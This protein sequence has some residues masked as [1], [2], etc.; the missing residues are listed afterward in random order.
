[1]DNFFCLKS[2]QQSG[3]RLYFLMVHGSNYGNFSGDMNYI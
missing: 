3:V 2:L 1:M